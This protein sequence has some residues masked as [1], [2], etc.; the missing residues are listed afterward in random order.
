M[1]RLPIT[2]VPG[3]DLDELELQPDEVQAVRWASMDEIR[4]LADGVSS[5]PGRIGVRF[6]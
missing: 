3:L 1:C 2:D 6:A 4:A 5:Q